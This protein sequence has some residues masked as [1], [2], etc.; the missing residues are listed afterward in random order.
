M[1]K[2]NNVAQWRNNVPCAER[3]RGL[4]FSIASFTKC[5]LSGA[6]FVISL[7]GMTSPASAQ[8]VYGTVRYEVAGGNILPAPSFRVKLCKADPNK[9]YALIPGACSTSNPSTS[10]GSFG[11]GLEDGN[12]WYYIFTWRNDWFWGSEIYPVSGPIFV[13]AFD[14][15]DQDITGFVSKPRA[16]QPVPVNPSHNSFN[17]P[18]SFTLQWSDGLDTSRRDP[19]WPVTYDIYASGNE[20]PE[21][22][23][24]SNIACNGT[25]TCSVNVSGLAYTTRYQWRVV[26]RMRSPI[27]VANFGENVHLTNSATF[28]FT[29]GFDPS[30]PTYSFRTA[31]GTRYLNAPNGGGG[32]FN[33]TTAFISPLTSQFKIIDVNGGSLMSGDTVHIQTSKNYYLMAFGGGGGDVATS[34]WAQA[35]ETFRI[36]KVGGTGQIGN[37]SSVALL[38]PNGIHYLVAENGGGGTVN[39]NSTTI[40]PWE[41]FTLVQQ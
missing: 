7:F 27:P 8:G 23:I 21:T 4:H 10:G 37:G 13:N 35:F 25:G 20:F 41:T 15:F 30:T 6:I 5:F 19:D 22:K 29:T 17:Q 31:N 18:I 36:I 39:C 33:A 14:D 11:L 28:K 1:N 2:L 3:S 34:G 9:N 26:A 40:G 32:D 24:F 38:G 12:G 16:L